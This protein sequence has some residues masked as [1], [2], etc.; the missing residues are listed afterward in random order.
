MP[1]LRRNI[2]SN[3]SNRERSGSA[4]LTQAC[5]PAVYK[6]LAFAV[7]GAWQAGGWPF[8]VAVATAMSFSC[9][10]QLGEI[11]VECFLRDY[12]QKQAL[13]VRAAFTNFQNPLSP[14]E[15]AGLS[16]EQ[17]LLS[18]LVIE[19]RQDRAESKWQTL[20]GPFSEAHFAQLPPSHWTLL[21]QQVDTL[22]PAVR[23]LLRAFAF[24]PRWRLED[25]MVSYAADQGSV[26]PHFD[27]YDVFLL[28]GQGARRWQLGQHCD[29]NT[30][31]RPSL[32]TKIL[33]QFDVQQ[34][35]LLQ[36]GDMLYIPPGV[37]H[38]GVAQGECITYSIGFRAPSHSEIL[39]DYF[40]EF[41]S[42]LSEDQRYSDPDLRRPQHWGEIPS[43]AIQQLQALLH[44]ANDPQ[45]L[46]R[47]FGEYMTQPLLAE[48]EPDSEHEALASQSGASVLNNTARLRLAP[49]LRCAFQSAAGQA[50]V[51][52]I[53]GESWPC[54]A[55]MAKQLS[56]DD[57]LDFAGLSSADK[58]L[59]QQLLTGGLLVFA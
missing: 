32:D 7:Y 57:T 13:L 58:Q 31:L 22:H 49:G 26:G 35:W 34:E 53:N 8:G 33:T 16:L 2:L 45:R 3:T 36:P 23:N 12:W 41:A 29:S 37:A 17:D 25:V 38:W 43:Q 48:Q 39:L 52:F 56:A 11:S 47:W 30:A 10:Q 55:P 46:A 50:A 15:L 18:R 44:S 40:T 6:H 14:D 4:Q 20:H 59:A 28:Q 27:Y 24:L 19:H 21:V 1:R 5:N 9:L 42:G 51:L 54:S